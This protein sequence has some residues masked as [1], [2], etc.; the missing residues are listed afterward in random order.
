M[1]T[2]HRHKYT[3]LI[4][5]CSVLFRMRNAADKSFREN[6]NTH[7]LFSNIF[8]KIVQWDKME[9]YCTAQQATDANKMRSMHFACWITKLTDTHS[10]YEILMLFHCNN[11]CTNTP[12]YFTICTMPVL[13][14]SHLLATIVSKQY[15]T[16]LLEHKFLSKDGKECVLIKMMLRHV[17][18]TSTPTTM[19]SLLVTTTVPHYFLC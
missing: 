5:S 15:Y 12:Q 1:G 4:I 13:L 18:W 6:K 8:L 19:K 17:V 3:F 9:K 16:C 11:G 10:A 2:L 14:D 7:F